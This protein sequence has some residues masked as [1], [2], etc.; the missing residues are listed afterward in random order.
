V[1]I[2][3]PTSLPV[4]TQP[5]TH[6]ATH[7]THPTQPPT[8]PA[9]HPASVVG[10]RVNAA[11]PAPTRAPGW[12]ADPRSPY[13]SRWR[14]GRRWTGHTRDLPRAKPRITRWV[15]PIVIAAL[16]LVVPLIVFAFALTPSA[17]LLALVP[18]ALMFPALMW[19][20]RVVPQP[21]GSLLYAFLWGGS[22]AIVVA[23]VV[24]LVVEYL[25][26]PQV[27]L[28]FGAPV[29]EELAKG[30]VL[31]I[32]LRRREIVTALDGVTYAAFTALGF[33][34]VED[35]LYLVEAAGDGMLLQTFFVRGVLTPFLHPLFTV[36]I[37]LLV[38]IAVSRRKS[39]VLL[40]GFGYVAAVVLHMLWN[41]AAL[42]ASL[43]QISAAFTPFILAFTIL[44]FTCV[45]L[46][47]LRSRVK[48]EFLTGVP[49]IAQRCALSPY[50]IFTFSN[51]QEMGRQ[52]RALARSSR[53]R[54]DN[55][56][57]C[58]ARLALTYGNDP[59]KYTALD[60]KLMKQLEQAR[61]SAQ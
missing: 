40:A 41:A 53:W 50:E 2:P 56:H 54:F 46:A 21:P 27:S 47:R 25:F 33:A 32:F 48:R 45:Y 9:P 39:V 30:A 42:L 18:V 15:S 13:L 31:I 57:A 52:R 26:G 6:P 5:P 34:F 61:H 43:T 19:L 7:P 58:I 12:Y 29:I 59:A 35:I 1:N 37:G 3:D 23:A 28:V 51:W 4:P 44:T 38:G 10:A 49:A 14:D 22:V 8:H 16:C 24:N 20:N 60:A 36:W 11:R 55:L 17:P